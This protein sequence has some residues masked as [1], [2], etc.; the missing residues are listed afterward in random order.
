MKYEYWLANIGGIGNQKKRELREKAGCA[1]E[2]YYIEE[3]GLKALGAEEKV[4]ACIVESKKIWGLEQEYERLRQR[5]VKFYPY[6]CDEYPTRLKQISAPPYAIYG[7]GRLPDEEKLSVAIVGARECSPYGKEMARWF[8]KSLASVGI[9][10]I[11]G[12]AKGVDGAGQLGALQVGGAT[13]GVLGCG[14][15]I[16]YPRENIELYTMLEKNGGILSEQPVG[17]KPFP[18]FFPARN[19]IISALS[20]V[21]LVME[22]KE[23]SGSLITAD[24][25]LEQGKDVYALP[26]PANSQ[27][28]RGCNRLIKQGAG[29]LLSPEELLEELGIAYREKGEKCEENKIPLESTENL[30]Y[31]CLDLYPKNINELADLTGMKIP[32]LLNVLVS[33]ELQ[34][35][36]SEFSKN[37]Y[38]RLK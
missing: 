35:Y 16:C 19:R 2:L 9:Q 5:R 26:G 34:G 20:D 7:K 38:I 11:S 12:M 29:I 28:S 17:M 22:A 31:S 3:T 4:I 14:V 13:F 25:A 36:I 23:R 8:A 33:L 1:K 10:N 6:F 24:M 30:V 32:A 37:H 27:L 21:V 18:Q 15:D